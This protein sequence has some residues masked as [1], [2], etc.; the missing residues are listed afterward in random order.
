MNAIEYICAFCL[1]VGGRCEDSYIS[2]FFKDKVLKCSNN[3]R[4]EFIH[5]NAFMI[6]FR[7]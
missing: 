4:S 5:V 1:R 7:I 6:A 2:D 3:Y